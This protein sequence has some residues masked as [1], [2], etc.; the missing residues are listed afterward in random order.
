M[1]TEPFKARSPIVQA[2]HVTPANTPVRPGTFASA[3]EKLR[4]MGVNRFHLVPGLE[5]GHVLFVCQVEGTDASATVHRF[6][7][8][9][10]D[11]AAAVADV[12]KQLTDW[13]AE[14]SV[15]KTAGAEFRR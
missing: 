8:E 13:Q 10:S 4:S 14:S 15:T 9:H 11:P 2:E 12:I 7:A 1:A 6:E 5:S 3:I